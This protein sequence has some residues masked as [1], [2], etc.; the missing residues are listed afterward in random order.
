M[1]ETN[2][3][4]FRRNVG[5]IPAV[6]MYALCLLSVLLLGRGNPQLV[7]VSMGIGVTGILVWCGVNVASWLQMVQTERKR[8]SLS[9][10]ERILRDKGL[11]PEKEGERHL[12]FQYVFNNTRWS[13]KYEE[14][15]GRLVI[16]L[17]FPLDNPTDVDLVRNAAA[18]VM[19][20]HQMVRLYQKMRDEQSLFFLVVETFQTRQV[21][22]E[23]FL[24]KYLELIVDAMKAHDAICHRA[25]EQRNRSSEKKKIGFESPM[26]D[27]I[28]EYDRT[29]PNASE[30]ERNSFIESIRK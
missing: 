11:S 29:N 16:G 10:I 20:T 1:N 12:R 2:Q 9:G 30:A 13:L 4:F 8:L 21:E 25:I 22:F 6:I 26:R 5:V 14:V 27:K 19:A 28:N 24:D 3:R 7:Y 23:R 15:T 18:D 17:V